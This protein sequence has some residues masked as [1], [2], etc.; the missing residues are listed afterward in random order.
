MPIHRP[1]DFVG[2]VFWSLAGAATLA[3]YAADVASGVVWVYYTPALVGF[4][5]AMLG[6]GG[7]LLWRAGRP[8]G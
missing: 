2:G 1:A 5:P 4:G 6:L 8:R 7:W 3:V